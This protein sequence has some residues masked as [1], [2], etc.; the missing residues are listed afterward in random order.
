M[1]HALEKQ[2]QEFVNEISAII[3]QPEQN[4][5]T[6]SVSDGPILTEE[7]VSIKVD[8]KTTIT[9]FRFRSK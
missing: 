9:I 6:Y 1:K 5:T 8:D 3:A 2:A 7:K 4:F